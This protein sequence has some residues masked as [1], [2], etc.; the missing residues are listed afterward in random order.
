MSDWS[1]DVCSSDLGVTPWAPEDEQM[2][3]LGGPST[4]VAW[5]SFAQLDTLDEQ[6]EA[7]LNMAVRTVLAHRCF[8]CHSSAKT[9]GKLRLDQREFVFMGVESGTVI[10]P[11]AVDNRTFYRHNVG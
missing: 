5:Q 9:E 1:S 3:A 8:Q 7:K 2:A 6:Q 4:D 10:L 11:V